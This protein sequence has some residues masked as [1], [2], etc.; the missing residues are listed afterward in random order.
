MAYVGFSEKAQ[1]LRGDKIQGL[2]RGCGPWAWFYLKGSIR[3]HTPIM[4]N[5]MEKETGA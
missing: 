4:E 1:G 3:Q 2:R 5:S